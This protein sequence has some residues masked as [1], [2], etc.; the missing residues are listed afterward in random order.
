LQVVDNQWTVKDKTVK[1]SNSISAILT[2]RIDRLSIILKETVKAAAVIGREFELP[3]LSE[4]ILQHDEYVRRNGNGQVVL[5]E[6]IQNAEKGQI[7]RA[8]NELRYIFRHS[9]LRETVYDMQMRTRLRE[10]HF[11]IAKAIEKVYADSIE[12]RYVDLAFHYEQ[13]EIKLKTNE[14]L[15]KAADFARRNF[16]NLQALEFYDRLLKN[17]EKFCN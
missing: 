5:R 4:V 14:Y 1:I 17:S 15:K 6:Q 9:L 11:M 3:V 2:A 12:Q 8:M 7:W 16:Q 13:A 10:L